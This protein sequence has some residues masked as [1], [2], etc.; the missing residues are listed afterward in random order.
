MLEQR[1]TW[2][3]GHKI[4]IATASWL[5]LEFQLRGPAKVFRKNGS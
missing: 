1:C 2:S 3:P 4:I 5:G